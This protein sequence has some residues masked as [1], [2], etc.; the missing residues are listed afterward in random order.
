MLPARPLHVTTDHA[1]RFLFIADNV[2]SRVTVHRLA[3]DGT[4]GEEI[5]QTG[6]PDFGIYAHQVRVHRATRP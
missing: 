5:A 3:A 4:I 6:K 2:P 1:G